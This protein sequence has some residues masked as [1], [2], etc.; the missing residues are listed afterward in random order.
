MDIIDHLYEEDIP[1]GVAI[2]LMYNGEILYHYSISKD[3]KC[4]LIGIYP[5]LVYT[6]YIRKLYEM[7]N[8]SIIPI[9]NKTISLIEVVGTDTDITFHLFNCIVEGANCEGFIVDDKTIII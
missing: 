1:Y 9:Y 2:P 5:K 4:Y 3:E 7:K 8:E 6:T